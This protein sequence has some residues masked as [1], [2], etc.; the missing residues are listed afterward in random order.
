MGFIDTRPRGRLRRPPVL[1]RA[2]RSAGRL[3]RLAPAAGLVACAEQRALSIFAPSTEAAR[4]LARLGWALLAVAA[5]VFVVFLAF[6]LVPLWRARGGRAQPTDAAGAGTMVE[7]RDGE[8]IVAVGGGAPRRA[9]DGETR[10][11]VLLGGVVP[12]LILGAAF[13]YSSAQTAQHGT[14][15]GGDAVAR[16]DAEIVVTGHQWWWEVRYP[17][18]G[19]VTANELHVPVGVPVRL[20]LRSADVIHSFWVP[21]LGGK[22]DLVPG[23]SNTLRLRA[24]SAGVYPGECAEY[25]GVQHAH[26][27]VTVV[28]EPPRAY[29]A[30]LAA[31]R[32]P[33]RAPPDG[34]I[35]DATADASVDD[36]TGATGAA[37][38]ARVLLSV[39]CA[40]CHTVR[41]TPAAGTVGPDLTHVASRRTLGAGV[42]PNTPGYLAGWVADPQALKPGSH[43]PAVPL[44]G[45]ELQALVDYLTQLR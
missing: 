15:R 42:V 44:T 20:V 7:A 35:D 16:D 32:A 12:L 13:A 5:V 8:T 40:A 28:A 2:T 36:T 17:G 11:I 18:A 43:M 27:G 31:Q 38:G 33:A 23:A 24:D 25:C 34:A 45:A 30:W 4:D 14:T 6:L 22:L 41:G 39:G 21:R 10:W 29:A 19:V 9:P 1:W 26:M 3:T 37:D